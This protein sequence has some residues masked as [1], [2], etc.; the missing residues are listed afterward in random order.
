[1]KADL[2]VHSKFS[3]RPNSWVLQKLGCPESF[4]EPKRIVKRAR[5]RGM[6]LL[7]ITDHNTIAG[8]LEIAHLPDTFLSM[9]TTTYFPEDQCKAHVLIYDIREDHVPEIQKLRHNILDLVTYLQSQNIVHA[10]AHPLYSINERLTV[11]HFER[12]LLLFKTFELN[13]AREALLNQV[14]DVILRTLTPSHIEKL[15]EKHRLEPAFPEPWM[16]HLVGGSDDHS[17]LDVARVYTEVPGARD[18]NDFLLGVQSGTAQIHGE[19]SS[20]LR[21]SHNLYSIAY[22][23]YKQRFHLSKHLHRDLFL[24]FLDRFLVQEDSPGRSGVWSKIYGLWKPRKHF[25]EPHHTSSVQHLLR[26][27]GQRL[28]QDDPELRRIIRWGY[29][30]QEEP[31]STWFEFVNR[32]SNRV[33]LHFGEN[34]IRQI[35][36]GNLLNLLQSAS[37]AGALFVLLSPYFVSFSLFAGDR[38]MAHTMAERFGVHSSPVRENIRP[39]NV[40]HFTDTYYEVNGVALTLQQQLALARKTHKQFTV[41]TCSA[42]P[43]L[44]SP[45]VRNFRPIG[46]YDLPEYPLLKLFC[47]PFLDIL[48][49][50][51]VQGFTHISTATPGPVGLAGLAVSKILK[52]PISGT[53]HTSLPQYTAYLTRDHSLEE[54]MWKYVIWYYDQLDA[55]YVPSQSTGRELADKGIAP[56]KIRLFPRG[57]DIVRFH[58][59][60]R[61]DQF[62]RRY[63]DLESFKLLYVGR[64]SKEKDLDLLVSVFKSLLD[65]GNRVSLLLAGEGPYQSLL[66]EKLEGTPHCFTGYLAGEA[67]AKLYA[68][69]DLFVFPSSTD[70]FG[71]V[72]LEAQ[73]SGLPVVVTDLG[74]PQ[75]NLI[76]RRTGLVVSAHDVR[77]MREAIDSLIRDPDML[78]R[79]GSMARAYMEDRSFEHAFNETWKMY[80]ENTAPH[81][82]DMHGFSSAV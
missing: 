71:N 4:T 43:S 13:G 26:R 5:E 68:S 28:I 12:F 78:R 16:K 63:T 56:E 19:P 20:P 33:L 14:L 66:Q 76:P 49:F 25:E 21:M 36:G 7:T 80:Y 48:Q 55:I 46:M 60:K 31:E 22:Q 58:P 30:E 42:D 79:M 10:L 70:T 17:S 65:S 54:L 47:P 38:R 41:I 72:V 67:L 3:K 40:A 69:C 6:S 29:Q 18:L 59:D 24:R 8:A 39:M 2:H 34:L 27:E 1:M 61:D 64:I 81:A 73:A 52:L 37:S 51:H 32:V 11:H 15:A 75:E 35:S 45:G 44:D 62:I 77:S 82:K 50:C 53:Y 9:E 57:I 74:G 23:F